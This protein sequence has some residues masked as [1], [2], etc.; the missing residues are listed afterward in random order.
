MDGEP[1][2]MMRSLHA[3]HAR[4]LHYYVAQLTGDHAFAQDVV[5]ETMA[6]AWQHPEVLE[7]EESAVRAW[8]FTVARNL[9][10]DDRRTARHGRERT[11]GTA[12]EA[13]APDVTQRVLDRWLVADALAGLS[14]EHRRVV[15][16]AYY[17]GQSVTEI[18]RSEGIPEG[19]V[20]S[21]LH[22]GLR[23]MRSALRE[24]GVT[25]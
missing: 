5:Q 16:D 8:L 1:D 19:T 2:A 18:A 7:R 15:V 13:P 4:P 17:G 20:K 22:Y 23:A 24:K 14:A 3:A 11:V 10:I 25:S 21:R 9:V 12:L 6:R